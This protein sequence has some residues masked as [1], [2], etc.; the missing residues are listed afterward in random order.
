MHYTVL[1]PLFRKKYG[2]RSVLLWLTSTQVHFS[3]N[4][5]ET[6]KMKI[7]VTRVKEIK[8]RCYEPKYEVGEKKRSTHMHIFIHMGLWL[9]SILFFRRKKFT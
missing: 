9:S 3:L 1:F 4:A 5:V 7:N 2:L 8:D 6:D